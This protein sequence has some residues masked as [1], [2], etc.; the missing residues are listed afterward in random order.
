MENN[1]LKLRSL[2]YFTAI[3]IL[4]GCGGNK[5]I[6]QN[7]AIAKLTKPI[8]LEKAGNT[9]RPNWTNNLTFFKDGQGL[10]FTAGVMDGAD[11]TLTA[12][13]AKA[14]AIKHLLESIEIKARSEFSTALHG[15]NITEADISRYITDAVAWTI[16]NI[17]VAGIKQRRM[18]Y[19]RIFDPASQTV[20]YNT[21]VEL[22]I[23]NSDYIKAKVN[24]VER[25][26]DKTLNDQ[27]EDTR[28]KAQEL[29]EKLRTKA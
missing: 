6:K 11:Y 23:P 26:L 12:R 5:V 19:E 8:L 4:S 29:L 17:K 10:H 25:L 7:Q 13:M 20:K 18:Y 27:N 22:V 21:W 16:D 24:A 14:E 3:T 15:K 9:G 1:R 2:I 28:K